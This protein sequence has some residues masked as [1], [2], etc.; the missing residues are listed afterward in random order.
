MKRDWGA[1]EEC[2]NHFKDGI[3]RLGVSELRWEAG[4]ALVQPG[5][6]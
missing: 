2:Q 6:G 1:W 3:T 5:A 4:C